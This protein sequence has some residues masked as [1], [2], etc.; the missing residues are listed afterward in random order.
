VTG[1]TSEIQF[2]FAVSAPHQ[3]WEG[4]AVRRHGSADL[5]HGSSYLTAVDQTRDVLEATS[6][7]ICKRHERVEFVL[8]KIGTHSMTYLRFILRRDPTQE[9]DFLFVGQVDQSM[10]ILAE[11]LRIG[12]RLARSV[13]DRARG[14][15]FDTD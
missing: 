11:L 14:G 12:A 5:G 7:I 10:M 9:R 13:G 1:P 3:S 2:D 4:G 8:Q 6:W 15:R